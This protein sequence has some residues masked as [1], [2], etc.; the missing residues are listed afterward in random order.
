VD[1]GGHAFILGGFKYLT[2]LHI[3]RRKASADSPVIV[4][5]ADEAQK[6]VNSYDSAF[7]AECRS[8]RGCMVCL[9]QSLHSFYSAIKGREGEHETDA[10]LTN[11]GTKIFHTVGDDKTAGFAA[12]LI[13]KSLQRFVTVSVAPEESLW[14]TMMGHSKVTP[15]FSERIESILQNNVFM[16]GLRTGGPPDFVADAIV[17]R[18]ESFSDGNNWKRVAFSQRG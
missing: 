12:S 9:T 17:I 1:S 13:G 16:T 14:E 4:I 15:S 11:F 7:L 3:L 2:Q 5:W 10:L 18:S 6:V 8:H